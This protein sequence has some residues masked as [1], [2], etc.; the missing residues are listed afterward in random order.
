[1]YKGAAKLGH[2]ETY[3]YAHDDPRGIVA[4][5]YAPD[6]VAGKTYYEPTSHGAEKAYAE[7]VEKIRRILAGEA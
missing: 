7:R 6:P 5:Q 4:Q 2:G 3:R 1:H